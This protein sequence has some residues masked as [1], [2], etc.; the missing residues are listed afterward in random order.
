MALP[1]T[2]TSGSARM[3][4]VYITIGT[5][6]DVWTV[7]WYIWMNRHGTTSDAPYY[8]CYG[9]FFTGLALI[10]IGLAI[11]RIGRAARHAEAPA[12]TTD[13]K[14]AQAQQPQQMAPQP[15]AQPVPTA[16]APAALPGAGGVPAAPATPLPPAPGGATPPVA[17]APGTFQP[18]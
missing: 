6:I 15:A 9:F 17:S 11:G 5:I 10:I 12:D 18:R 7:I 13:S 4:V 16:M 1:H 2:K 8:W 14:N 3:S